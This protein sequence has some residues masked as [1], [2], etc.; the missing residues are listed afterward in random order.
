MQKHTTGTQVVQRPPKQIETTFL[1]IRCKRIL[2]VDHTE[3]TE[4][5][6]HMGKT[7]LP[8]L[9]SGRGS[10]PTLQENISFP[11]WQSLENL[12][13]NVPIG[14]FHGA[15]IREIAG[16]YILDK[17]ISQNI[18]MN[19]ENTELYRVDC[20]VATRLTSQQAEKMSWKADTYRKEDTLPKYVNQNSN[21]PPAIICNL[22]AMIKKSFWVMQ[23]TCHV[24]Q[25]HQQGIEWEWLQLQNQTHTPTG[26]V[27]DKKAQGE[28]SRHF[29]VQTAIYNG[30]SDK[31]WGSHS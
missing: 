20:L 16:L 7:V 30:R 19:K 13:F 18:G 27:S 23:L 6:Y 9:W 15:E 11:A 28:I 1:Y 22:P 4:E 12:D 21:H 26:P 3:P 17:L 2:P 8:H 24:W 10:V 31:S 29:L 5:C 25:T 14:S